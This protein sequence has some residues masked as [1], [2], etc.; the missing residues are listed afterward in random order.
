MS[1]PETTTYIDQ[2]GPRLFPEEAISAVEDERHF[3]SSLLNDR[4]VAEHLEEQVRLA[5]LDPAPPIP[6]AEVWNEIEADM[7][8]IRAA[9]SGS[10]N[11]RSSSHKKAGR[12]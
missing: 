9:Y 12:T 5:R 7:P 3:A 2:Q 11:I 4:R 1:K 8:E 6:A 10:K